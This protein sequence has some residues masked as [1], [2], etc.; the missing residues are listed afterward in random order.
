MA[1]KNPSQSGQ[2]N[3][4][5]G[6]WLIH[7]FQRHVKDDPK[8]RV[9]G[10]DFLEGCPRKVAATM[11]AVLKA[12]SEAPPPKFS[13]GGKWEAMHGSMGGFYEIRVDGP[14][15]HHYRLF[16][17]LERDGIALGLGGPSIVIITGKDKPFRSVF[18]ESD[19]REV[20][21]LGDEYR[22][23]TPRSFAL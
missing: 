18:S 9:P 5:S 3:T 13:G 23:R 20:K 1:R 2:D 21:K 17:I 4:W 10:R 6:P 19:Y 22:S 12:V 15:R 7:F 11:A 16:C 8:R 14:N